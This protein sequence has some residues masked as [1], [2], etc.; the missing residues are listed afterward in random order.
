MYFCGFA[1]AIGLPG[2]QCGGMQIEN[3]FIDIFSSVCVAAACFDCI[4]LLAESIAVLSF[5]QRQ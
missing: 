3:Q 1:A 2:G 4:Y 5:T